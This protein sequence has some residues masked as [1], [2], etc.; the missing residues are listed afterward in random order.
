[1]VAGR[2]EQAGLI[3]EKAAISR[4]LFSPFKIQNQT[5]IPS[6]IFNEKMNTNF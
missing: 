4:V 2:E 3:S 6:Y 5:N 1:M